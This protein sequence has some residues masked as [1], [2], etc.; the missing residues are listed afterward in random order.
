[1]VRTTGPGGPRGRL[2]VFAPPGHNGPGARACADSAANRRAFGAAENAPDD[3]AAD[4][5]AA[6]LR[7]ALASGRVAFAHHRFGV[8]RNPRAVCQHDRGEAHAK[9]RP[10]F[11][12]ATAF[13]E[14]DL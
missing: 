1:D 5:A 11:Q 7:G 8:T 4:G 13:H 2:R 14:R 12:A 9:T 3:R 6:D 10:I